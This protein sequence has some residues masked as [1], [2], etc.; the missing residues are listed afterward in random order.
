MALIKAVH[1]PE[2]WFIIFV[3]F[4]IGSLVYFS[5][6]SPSIPSRESIEDMRSLFNTSIQSLSAAIAIVVSLSLVAVQL[7]SQAYGPR[8]LKVYINQK[9]LWAIFALF[10]VAIFYDIVVLNAM[11]NHLEII[12]RLANLSIVLTFSC[13][14]SLIPLIF[15][16]IEMLRPDELIRLIS[17]KISKEYIDSLGSFTDYTKDDPLNS[18]LEI[19]SMALRQD[20]LRTFTIIFRHI[21][22]SLL[23]HIDNSNEEI[24]ANKYSNFSKQVAIMGIQNGKEQFLAIIASFL[25]KMTLATNEKQFEKASRDFSRILSDIGKLALEKDL[26]ET[27]IDV[28]YSV[29]DIAKLE[30]E[31]LPD[32]DDILLFSLIRKTELT[33]EERKEKMKNDLKFNYFWLSRLGFFRNF[34]LTS[35]EKY[36][37]VTSAVV[38]TFADLIIKVL[39]MKKGDFMRRRLLL[40][41]MSSL[42]EI[43]VKSIEKKFRISLFFGLHVLWSVLSDRISVGDIEGFRIVLINLSRIYLHSAENGLCDWGI[44]NDLGTIGRA[45]VKALPKYEE[46]TKFV[47]ETLGKIGESIKSEM[48]AARGSISSEKL[49]IDFQFVLEAI[50]SIK[51]WEKHSNQRVIFTAENWLEKLKQKQALKKRKR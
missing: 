10:L 15:K 20:D 38:S 8:I 30:L 9:L 42:N 48:L 23:Q 13:F 17:E 4:I 6:F 27:A 25:R 2:A 32:E 47:T 41:L 24:I 40:D 11:S 1:K 31:K 22:A 43:C 7:A 35:I 26:P 18:L 51:T 28:V 39:E 50:N 44:I 36:E 12:A 45:M 49:S 46:E 21:S 34:G 16:T 5:H 33:E 3:V 14:L 19:A 37:K 29:E